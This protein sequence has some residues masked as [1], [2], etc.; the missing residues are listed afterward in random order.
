MYRYEP[1]SK[2]TWEKTLL[3]L[4]LLLGVIAF[5][6]STIRGILFPSLLQL[7]AVFMLVGVVMITSRCLMRRFIY[8]VEPREGA[9]EGEPLDLVIT[10]VYG[11]RMSVVC[12]ISVADVVEVTSITPESRKEISALT[13]GKLVYRYTEELFPTDYRMLTTRMDEEIAYIK[14]SANKDLIKAIFN[15]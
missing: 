11:N 14:I 10:E 5:A 3:L 15:H 4:F 12:R 7:F 1:K 6:T 8:S 9:S 2:K 13:K